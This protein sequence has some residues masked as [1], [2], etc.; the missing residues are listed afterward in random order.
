MP[1]MTRAVEEVQ[2][3]E[4]LAESLAAALGQRVDGEAA[5]DGGRDGVTRA[6]GVDAGEELSRLSE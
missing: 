1:T 5:G 6:R 4:G 3:Q 2:A